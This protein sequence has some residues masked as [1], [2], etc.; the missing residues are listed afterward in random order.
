MAPE[1]SAMGNDAALCPLPAPMLEKGWRRGWMEGLVGGISLDGQAP[2][3]AP[4]RGVHGLEPSS[5][6]DCC[7][8]TGAPSRFQTGNRG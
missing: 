1:R 4:W 2:K 3:A 6:Q 8:G 7:C 5:D